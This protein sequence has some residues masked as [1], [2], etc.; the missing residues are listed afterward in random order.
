MINPVE[1]APRGLRADLAA[2]YL[3]MS[4]TKFLEL[5]SDDR[6]PQPIAIDAMRVW[7][8][9][10]LDAAFEAFKKNA[11]PV[12]SFDAILGRKNAKSK[13]SVC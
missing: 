5:V 6:L 10:E 3:G 7:D 12:N 13:A 9:F 1:Y 8:R 4:R 11:E 2:A